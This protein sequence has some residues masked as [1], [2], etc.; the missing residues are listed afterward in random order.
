[1][2]VGSVHSLKTFVGKGAWSVGEFS[3][4]YFSLPQQRTQ[5]HT[6][7]HTQQEQ[8]RHTRPALVQRTPRLLLARRDELDG[9]DCDAN[10]QRGKKLDALFSRQGQ[11]GTVHVSVPEDCRLSEQFTEKRVM[12]KVLVTN[13]RG[14]KKPPSW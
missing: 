4:S 10:V 9:E 14:E 3:T 1:M 2:Q 11:V 7:T 8:S 6:A 12:S 5:R 13:D